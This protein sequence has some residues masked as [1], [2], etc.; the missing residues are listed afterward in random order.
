MRSAFSGS[1]TALTT[2]LN[3][4]VDF[5]MADLWTLTLSG[6]TVIR[7]CGADKPLT[8][9]DARVFPLGPAINRSKISHK[10]GLVV[11]TMEAIVM[12]YDTDLINGVPIIP[13][14]RGHGLDG[15]SIM[16]EKAFLPDWNSAIT[17]TL[18][19]FAGRVT[20]IKNVGSTEF[21]LTASSWMVLLST[22]IGPNLFQ[23]SCLHTTF[24]A[25][26]GLTKASFAT[27]GAV[28]AGT[29]TTSAFNTNLTAADNYFTQGQIVFT[30]GVN[31]GLSRSIKS[32]LHAS[33]ALTLPFP[34]PNAPGVGDTFTVYPG[35]DHTMATCSGKFSNL[36]HFRA[37]PFIP[38]PETAL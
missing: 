28:A 16:L 32:H 35:D 19:D 21:T 13:F 15:A 22:N 14:V 30:S 31:N 4:G 29:P 1:N 3:S 25:G 23:P 33:G 12:A 27:S 7:W 17:A 2:L 18:I 38:V 11:S 20:S 36:V 8:T 26:C 5:E 37:F 9:P 24:D 6:G 10:T 34:L